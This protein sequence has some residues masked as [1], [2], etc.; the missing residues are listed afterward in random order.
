[1]IKPVENLPVWT[2]SMSPYVTIFVR[3]SNVGH[4]QQ[5]L[6]PSWSQLG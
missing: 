1:M 5:A 4:Y 2:Y 6:S 3:L